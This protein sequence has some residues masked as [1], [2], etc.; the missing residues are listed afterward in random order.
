MLTYKAM[1]KY[2]DE[3]VHA[4]VLDFPGA[5]T[6]GEDLTEARRLLTAALV[7]VAET[8]LFAGEPLPPPDP[9]CTDPESDLE[10]PISFSQRPPSPA[11]P[12]AAR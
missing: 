4:E 7:D 11:P 5:I 1:Y 2:L 12:M 8:L 3:G 6:C 10:E 9:M